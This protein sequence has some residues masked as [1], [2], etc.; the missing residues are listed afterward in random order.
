M[1]T[2]VIKIFNQILTFFK[3][4]SNKT[5]KQSKISTEE[6]LNSK[7]ESEIFITQDILEFNNFKLVTNINDYYAYS[8]I[9]GRLTINNSY[10]FD[11]WDWVLDYNRQTGGATS[12]GRI[13]YVH[14][15]QQVLKNNHIDI[16]IKVNYGIYF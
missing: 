9:N 6:T 4:L 1:K 13:R 5:T 11:G 8:D 16:Q 7:S 2:L 14:E 3:K 12:F 10:H 15:L